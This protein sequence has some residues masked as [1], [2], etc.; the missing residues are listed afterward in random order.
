MN[1]HW[2]LGKWCLSL[3]AYVWKDAPHEEEQK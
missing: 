1:I 2:K 3:T